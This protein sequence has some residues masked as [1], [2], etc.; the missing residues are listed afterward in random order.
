[1]GILGSYLISKPVEGKMSM[2]EK[3][4]V[5]SSPTFFI[6]K[7]FPNSSYVR[8]QFCSWSNTKISF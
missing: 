6:F 1:M 5:R 7:K 2:I 4:A 3:F 8:K